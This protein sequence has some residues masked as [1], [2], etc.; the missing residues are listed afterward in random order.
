MFDCVFALEFLSLTVD[1]VKENRRGGADVERI[2]RGRHGNG[3]RSIAGFQ[4]GGGNAF[5]LAAEDD[6]AIAGKI[7][8]EDGFLLEF[9]L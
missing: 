2:H 7:S 5:A 8:A 4:D 6:A 1:F 9:K 3:H